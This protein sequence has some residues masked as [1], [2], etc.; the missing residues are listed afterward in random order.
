MPSITPAAPVSAL[1]SRTRR[2][3]RRVL[4]PLAAALLALAGPALAENRVLLSYEATPS[5]GFDLPK[6]ADAT[7]A[8]RAAFAGKML[9]TIVPRIAEAVGVAPGA[10]ETEVT[11]GGYML[12]TNA[13]LQSESEIDDPLADRLAA[14]LGYVFRQDSVLVSRFDD[15]KGKTFYVTVSFPKDTLDAKTAQS[16]FEK[17]DA[18]A[19]GLGGGYTAFGDDQ[20]FLNVTDDAG[21]PYSGLTD[22]AFLEGLTKTAEA[23]APNKPAISQSG[24]VNARFVGNDWEKSAKG[25]DYVKALGGAGAAAVTALDAIEADYA[26]EVETAAKQYGWK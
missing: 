8:D 23:F 15:P 18:T 4:P 7:Y 19:K 14:A 1:A 21:K 20:I 17:A 25:E 26:K 9:E 2:L 22:K 13:S 6:M 12:K 16:F 5:H 24:Q 10:L 3:L 11:P